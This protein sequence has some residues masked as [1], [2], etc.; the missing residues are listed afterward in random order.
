MVQ[1]RQEP[2][3]RTW[4][5]LSLL[6]SGVESDTSTFYNWSLGDGR[7]KYSTVGWLGRIVRVDPASPHQERKYYRGFLGREVHR[8]SIFVFPFPR[9]SHQILN[10]IWG[11]DRGGSDEDQTPLGLPVTVSGTLQEP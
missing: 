2:L 10:L 3:V 11:Q 4:E 1:G 9:L 7:E 8:D 6:G 5:S